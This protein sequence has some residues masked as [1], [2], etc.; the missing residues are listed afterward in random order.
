MTACSSR[1]GFQVVGPSTTCYGRTAPRCRPLPS[2]TIRL[3][4]SYGRADKRAI[5]Q[6]SKSG[7]GADFY[8][9]QNSVQTGGSGSEGKIGCHARARI[10]SD[11]HEGG[12]MPAGGHARVLRLAIEQPA[13]YGA[14][15]LAH[16]LTLRGV[17]IDGIPRALHH[18]SDGPLA[19]T[20]P[21]TVLAEHVSVPLS[22]DVRLTNKE[23][24]NLHAEL[25]LLLAAHE[26]G[27]ATSYEEAEKF[28]AVFFKTAS[29]AD[30]DVMLTDG[31]GKLS[32]G[33]PGH[34]ARRRC[35]LLLY[36]AA[37]PWSDIYRLLFAGGWRGWHAER[38][39]EGDAGSR[40]HFRKN[41]N[42]R[43]RKFTFW[44]CRR[45]RAEHTWY[46]LFSETTTIFTRR[47]RTSRSM[48]LPWRWWRSWSPR[49]GRGGKSEVC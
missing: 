29:I 16:L 24:E 45:L 27:G 42:H 32:R 41:W 30:G 43:A 22:E 15:L 33:R 18:A 28:A 5:R 36:A 7:P 10:A 8:T 3:R 21:Q 9:I 6:R 40:P 19:I 35:R 11:S 23:S 1:S 46:F 13:E 39:H 44:L 26:M 2:M 48:R 14:N 34:A 49:R 31:S 4:S 38:T 37:Q 47:P 25:M 20:P 17:R 12:S